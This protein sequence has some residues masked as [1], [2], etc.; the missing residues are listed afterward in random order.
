MQQKIMDLGD[1]SQSLLTFRVGPV[2]CCAP[3]LPVTSIIP[4]P[5]L[6]HVPGSDAGQP[7]IFRHGSHIIKVL[8][9]RQKFGIDEADKT[10]PG[11]LIVT[12]FDEEGVAFWVDQILD[13]FEFP[14]K[15]W[16][17]LPAAIPRGIFSRTLLLDNKIHL[18]SEFEKLATISELGY[19]RQYILQLQQ[20]ENSREEDAVKDNNEKTSATPTPT[21]AKTVKTT[22]NPSSTVAATKP[23]LKTQPQQKPT[24]TVKPA[25]VS[26]ST[27]TPSAL[28]RKRQT[29]PVPDP[30]HN[31]G[32][33]AEA[34]KAVTTVRPARPEKKTTA[35]TA[36]PAKSS[37]PPPETTA[38]AY[39]ND[40]ALN[41][42][43]E[44][45]SGGFLLLVVLLVFISAISGG[46]YLLF[47]NSFKPATPV[48]THIDSPDETGAQPAS[49]DTAAVIEPTDSEASETETETESITTS[50]EEKLA[51]TT[52]AATPTT[53]PETEIRKNY[54]ANIEHRHNEILITVHE[55]EPAKGKEETTENEAGVT[56]AEANISREQPAQNNEAVIE[57]KS[58]TVEKVETKQVAEKNNI[59]EPAPAKTETTPSAKER[60]PKPKTVREVVHIVVKGDTLWAIAKKYVHD[61]FRYP[62]LARLSKIRNPD[63]IYPGNRVR[64]RFVKD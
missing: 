35:A 54:L 18:Y 61:P 50:K 30:D 52:N 26:H 3:S 32:R 17:N 51:V 53:D 8:D 11:I 14:S 16:G 15:G 22:V 34:A 60:K 7:G 42:D 13:V 57:E 63:R 49:E 19:L 41:N 24:N 23:E 6:T 37:S 9:L 29:Q 47:N 40:S 58:A 59:A 5:K 1:K 4:P 20:Q 43:E 12:L 56:E 62:E 25:V 45:S 64:I 48:Y 44:Q 2:L 36:P 28:N 21:P 31:A 38:P 33:T 55:P 10:D 46:L 39:H 27:T